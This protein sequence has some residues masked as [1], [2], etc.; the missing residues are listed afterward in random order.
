MRGFAAF[1]NLKTSSLARGTDNASPPQ[2]YENGAK[3]EENSKKN[4]NRFNHYISL[5]YV[6]L[7]NL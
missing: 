6:E 1:T 2:F 5:K 7:E 3:N 4:I